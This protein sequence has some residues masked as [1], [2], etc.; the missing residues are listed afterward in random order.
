MNNQELL[1][2]LDEAFKNPE[3]LLE[4][5]ACVESFLDALE[6]GLLRAAYKAH[7][8]WVVDSRVKQGILRAFQ[9]GQLATTECGPLSFVDKENLWPR[10]FDQSQ[11]VRLVPGGSAVRRGAFVGK[12][13]VIMPPSYINIG[14]YVD[15]GSL[16][17]SH[18]LVG[19]CAQIGKRVH[20]SAGAQI[21]GVLE[22]VGSLPVIIEDDVLVGGN[23]G[24]YEGVHVGEK[25]VLGAGVILTK[26]THVYDMVNERIISAVGEHNLNIPPQAVVVPG[27]RSLNHQFAKT[28]GLSIACPLIIKYRDQKTDAKASLEKLLR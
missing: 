6:A 24:L 22:P 26:S 3:A 4:Q 8:T 13:V 14:A 23:C 20:I 11:G 18:A 12:Q 5:H 27:A 19:S 28:H 21:G 17:D 10:S 2:R 15:D 7:D 16:I 9:I 1:D 25:A